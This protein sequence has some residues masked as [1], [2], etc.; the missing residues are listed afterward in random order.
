METRF[1]K[2]PSSACCRLDTIHPSGPLST[3]HILLLHHQNHST[4][5]LIRFLTPLS[6]KLVRLLER[7]DDRLQLF[8]LPRLLFTAL[9]LP[10]PLPPLLVYIRMYDDNTLAFKCYL[11]NNNLHSD[12]PTLDLDASHPNLTP[13]R[14]ISTNLL[15]PYLHIPHP[16]YINP[17]SL[18][19]LHPQIKAPQARIRRPSLSWPRKPSSSETDRT[20]VRRGIHAFENP[21]LPKSALAISLCFCRR[22]RLR[23]DR[24][25]FH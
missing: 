16:H 24:S 9:E 10:S 14:I 18:D 6:P 19:L 25:H 21:L 12:S 15:P 5:L 3:I 22:L 17:P 2:S 4:S 23:H 1:G 8:R 13:Y 11:Y 7:R 20:L